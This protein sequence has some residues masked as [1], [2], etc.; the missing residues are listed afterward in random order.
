MPKPTKAELLQRFSLA[1]IS[2]TAEGPVAIKLSDKKDML[3]PKI[4]KESVRGSGSGASGVSDPVS[5]GEASPSP[6][7]KLEV[8]PTSSHPSCPHVSFSSSDALSSPHETCGRSSSDDHDSSGW[9][10][11]EPADAAYAPM[12]T[13]REAKALSVATGRFYIVTTLGRDGLVPGDE[14]QVDGMILHGYTSGKPIYYK[15]SG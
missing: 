3:K 7:A 10:D 8:H 1:T 15:Y 9:S 4:V 13:P 2:N 12:C 11:F 5:S 6:V 14:P